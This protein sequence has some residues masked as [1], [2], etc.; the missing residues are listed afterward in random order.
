L[1]ILLL[2]SCSGFYY[3]PD[4]LNHFP[5]ENFGYSYEVLGIHSTK[6]TK[7]NAY[8]FK[9]RKGAPKGTVLFFHGNAENLTSHYLQL[10]WLIE[11][12]Y[13]LLIFDY[14]GYGKSQG[15]PNPKNLRQDGLAM[16][17]FTYEKFFPDQTKKQLFVAYG[18]SLGGAVLMDAL[19]EF[20]HL[21]KLD[22]VV[23]DSTFTDYKALGISKL[24][25]HWSFYPLIPFAYLLLDNAG[26]STS[27]IEEVS[28]V[29][30]LVIHGT[31]DPVVPFE[32]GEQIFELAKKPK[33]MWVIAD[34]QH[35]DAFFKKHFDYRKKF[36]KYLDELFA[37]KNTDR[38][39][40]PR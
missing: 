36:A 4:K 10:I 15:S 38:F 40:L 18:Q 9:A 31:K 14:Q 24:K 13:N 30:L 37:K 17:N 21:D 11:Y 35:T 29:P 2:S 19:S 7:L 39:T 34:G 26:K 6:D 1:S 25:T 33:T 20:D 22:L 27:F 8:F 3:Y 5:P 28:P 32:F 12:G 16:L 23:M